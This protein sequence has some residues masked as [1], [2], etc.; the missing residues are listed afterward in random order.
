MERNMCHGLK[1][2]P[3]SVFAL[4]GDEVMRDRFLKGDV[5]EVGRRS[6]YMSCL[7]WWLKITLIS[8]DCIAFSGPVLDQ[9]NTLVRLKA[10]ST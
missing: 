10:R 4:H 5:E 2:Q 3:R 6:V 1:K 7:K 8:Q 9:F